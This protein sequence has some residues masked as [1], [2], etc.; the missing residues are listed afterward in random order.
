MWWVGARNAIAICG[1][2]HYIYY[3]A[4]Q[5]SECSNIYYIIV[6]SIYTIVQYTVQYST[7]WAVNAIC[8]MSFHINFRSSSDSPIYS[9][10]YYSTCTVYIHNIVQY[11]RGHC[12]IMNTV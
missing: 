4:A 5:Y 3:S 6:Q 8:D 9:T 7:V 10:S 2:P 1:R 12:T 11:S